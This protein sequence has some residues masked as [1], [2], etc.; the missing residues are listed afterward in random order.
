MST[1]VTPFKSEVDEATSE[2]PSNTS[3]L[4]FNPDDLP[5]TEVSRLMFLRLVFILMEDIE[6]FA[7]PKLIENYINS[8]ET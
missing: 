5:R 2:L 1:E 4:I 8:S 6:A 3:Y 7:V